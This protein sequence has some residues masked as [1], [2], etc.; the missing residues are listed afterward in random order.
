MNASRSPNAVRYLYT[1]PAF[2][3]IDPRR[4]NSSVWTLSSW[5][6]RALRFEQPRADDDRANARRLQVATARYQH[7]AAVATER[8]AIPAHADFHPQQFSNYIRSRRLLHRRSLRDAA[9]RNPAQQAAPCSAVPSQP[10]SS[11]ARRRFRCPASSHSDR[12]GNNS[13]LRGKVNAAVAEP[14]HDNAKASRDCDGEQN[15]LRFHLFSRR[16]LACCSASARSSPAVLCRDQSRSAST[17]NCI[18]RAD[19]NY[20]NDAPRRKQTV[21]IIGCDFRFATCALC[22]VP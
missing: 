21:S 15:L 4:A 3:Q 8:A 16:L 6:T 19:K 5:A 18:A 10:P 17:A 9:I 11:K 13:T 12:V 20:V 14:R 7:S 2:A 22:P 1:R